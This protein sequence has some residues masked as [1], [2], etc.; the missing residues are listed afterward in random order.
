MVIGIIAISFSAIFVR[1]SD[2]PAGVIAMHRLYMTN[3]L[4]LPFLGK[5]IHDL[6]KISRKD[7]LLLMISGLF[8]GLHFLYWMNSL[9]L[10]TVASSTAIL[11]LEPVLVMAGSYWVFKHQPSRGAVLSMTA[12]IFGA[13][14]IGWGDY[15]LSKRAL[16]GDLLSL[17]GAA[18]VAVH[19][20]LGKSLRER[21]SSFLYNFIVFFMAASVLAVYNV[22]QG[23]VIWHYGMKDWGVFALLAIVPTIFGHYLFNW[24]LKYVPATS[25]SAM[26]LGEPVGATILA[27]LLLKESVTFVQVI[28]GALLIIGVWLFIRY[29]REQSAESAPSSALD[30][31]LAE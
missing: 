12:A 26:V 25:V 1:W 16:Q 19:M 13:V 7:L 23:S 11:S 9:R 15:S 18:A 29:N 3:L 17:L 30:S 21:V 8:L 4:L 2:A 5:H 22:L 31:A 24:L 27:Y 10:T 20:M 6:R 14:L 28:A